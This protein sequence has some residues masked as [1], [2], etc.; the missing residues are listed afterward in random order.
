MSNLAVTHRR[1]G[2]Y[3]AVALAVLIG[4]CTAGHGRAA[5]A[6]QLA[7]NF[8]AP[9]GI[10]S[11]GSHLWVADAVFGF[12]R[13]D[14]D[15]V[16]GLFLNT[17]TCVK[18]LNGIVGQPAYDA[19]SGIVYLPDSQPASLGVWRYQFDPIA[20]IFS[21][22]TIVAQTSGLGGQRPRCVAL[23]PDGS[24][25]MTSSVNGSVFRI[26]HPSGSAFGQ[27]FSTT[28]NGKPA[29]GL[30]FLDVQLLFAETTA[31]TMI[32]DA[33]TCGT[34]CRS[35]A[36][37]GLGV[38][39]PTA[40][41]VDPVAR[42][43][44][45]GTHFGVF[46]WTRSTG[47]VDLYSNSVTG[48]GATAPYTNI[49]GLGVDTAGNLLVADDPAAGQAMGRGSLYEV[50]AGS[51]I[52]SVGPIPTIPALFVPSIDTIPIANPAM[53][54]AGRLT[55]P[56]GANWIG[57][58]LWVSDGL[59]GFCRVDPVAGILESGTCAQPGF[60]MVGQA[61]LDA[62]NGRVYVPATTFGAAPALKPS[63][64]ISFL[65]YNAATGSVSN[66][67]LPMVSV[68][69]LGG[70]APTCVALGPDGNLYVGF[71]RTAT[72]LRI[73]NPAGTT[74]VIQPVGT[75]SDPT[76]NAWNM[77]FVGNDLWIAE[78]VYFSV[79]K[80]A[81]S[82][83]G[84][85]KP[86]IL[87]VRLINP[88]TVAWD[89]TY[90][91]VGGLGAVWR[92]NPAANTFVALADQGL[93]NGTPAP[94]GTVSG[95]TFDNSGHLLVAE[96]PIVGTFVRGRPTLP[97]GTVWFL[98]HAWT[99]SVAP[100]R[101][102]FVTPAAGLPGATVNV[103]LGGNNFASGATVQAGAGITA[104]NVTV[105]NASQITATLAIAPNTAPGPRN[106]TVGTTL[107]FSNALTFTVSAPP[108]A[109]PPVNPPPPPINPP[110]PPI[111]P[112]PPPSGTAPTITSVT[113]ASGKAGST[114]GVKIMGA[115]LTS[116]ATVT[117]AGGAGITVTNVKLA[118][119]TEIDANFV[120]P[121]GAAVGP[122][123]VTVTTPGGTSNSLTFTVLIH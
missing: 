29:L 36:N 68:T 77:A 98:G 15:P 34:K 67:L 103:T 40:L 10:I 4:L 71:L 28:S 119:P 110:P 46:R 70:D 14:A 60:A 90:V 121:A 106:I 57:N 104:S 27:A 65:G 26:S 62:A 9:S 100:P 38:S 5:S 23:G 25:Y 92:Y 89:G 64:G 41:A 32:P 11:A 123:T 115:N 56:N 8:T 117:V 48:L 51:P 78:K 42:L 49:T 118:N 52:S 69:D 105:V 79:I 73:T 3:P 37:F 13:L 1:F 114:Q 97:P 54:D 93:I 35:A 108:V 74:H 107:G 39:S 63:G 112:P 24:L 72:I 84:T 122:Q 94:F 55:A 30:Q 66:V 113:P 80:N 17:L 82:C 91:Y 88:K 87:P 81:T 33:T 44:Y 120:I 18:P 76:T 20:E 22:P 59:A 21:G 111:N 109:P 83:S 47:Q 61:A 31:I 19:A 96:G 43:L 95:L 75:L 50:P 99:V 16:V 7:V 53:F 85:C 58:R 116:G 2:R 86:L 45:I 6:T 101:L 12:C 102:N